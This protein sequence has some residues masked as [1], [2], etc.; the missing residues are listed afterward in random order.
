MTLAVAASSSAQPTIPNTVPIVILGTDALLA[1][2]P[3]TPVQLAHACLRAGFAN[4]V[5][6]S[7]GDE[8]IAASVLRR[9][10]EYGNGPAIQCSC[11]IVAHRLLSVSGDLRPAMLALVAPPVA[12]ARY[13]R[14][15]SQ[16]VR[17]RIT[18]VGSC[19]GANDDSIDIRMRP[20]AL[21]A[22]LAERQIVLDEQPRMF[23]SIIPPD[24]R[25]FRSQPGGVPTTEALWTE[26]GSRTLVEIDG[27][28]LVSEIAQHLLT[29]KNV[30]IDAG[31]R[32][33]CV[34]SGALSGVPV[35]DARSA[36]TTLEPPRSTSPVV[37]EQ[38]PID[39]DLHIPATP[40]TPVDVAAVPPNLTPARPM[41]AS[42]GVVG[43]LG[44]RASP[45]RGFN[46]DS[47]ARSARVTPAHPRPVLGSVPVARAIE[48]KALPRAFVARRRSSP[49]G[50]P[51][52][53]LPIDDPTTGQ[54]PSRFSRVVTPA[55]SPVVPQ[56]PQ[57]PPAF[58]PALEVVRSASLMDRFMA[59]PPTRRD[60]MYLLIGVLAI[61][62]SMST[63]VGVIV[64][65]LVRQPPPVAAAPSSAPVQR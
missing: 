19:P 44:H 51:A 29:G 24:R 21:L 14:A 2:L 52:I 12:I 36:V 28:D 11:P 16:P 38:A 30:L 32:L 15:L 3:A 60:L 4:V 9:L 22:M 26:F 20:D 49:K 62:L 56:T 59:N 50:M 43:P 45:A 47:D 48:R 25:R 5:P 1:A 55:S 33:G 42:P 31:P 61:A 63:L 54:S 57:S 41:P 10:P 53:A 23:E 64:G 13:V 6:A 35:K 65:R 7:W 46:P 39:L 17:T 58:Q 40:R 27:E 37:E 18:Y 34:C 8:L